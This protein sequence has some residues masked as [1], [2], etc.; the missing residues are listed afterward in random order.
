MIF[1]TGSIHCFSLIVINGV[2]SF[3]V[4]NG[5][6]LWRNRLGQ[7]ANSIRREVAL[8]WVC[9]E[10][11]TWFS[12]HYPCTRGWKVKSKSRPLIRCSPTLRVC[13]FTKR[14]G[15]QAVYWKSES[16][17]WAWKLVS[18]IAADTTLWGPY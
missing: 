8:Y 17:F 11:H 16:N 9:M 12:M 1:H 3:N 10:L 6:R 18:I 4:Q 13:H 7:L 2:L 14:C 15:C 5:D